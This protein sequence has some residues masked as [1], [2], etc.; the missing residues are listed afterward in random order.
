[1][2]VLLTGGTGYIGSHTAVALINAGLEV[3]IADDLSN[4]SAD[5]IDRIE[6]ICGKKPRFFNIDVRKAD[7]LFAVFDSC[8]IESTVHLAGFKAVGESVKVPLKYY[9]NNIDCALT[10]LE[11][12]LKYNVKNIV[13]SSSATVYGPENPIPYVEAMKTGPCSNPYGST[14]LMI[15]QII[16]DTVSANP[17]MSAVLL[18]YFNPVG[19]HQSGLMGELPA[20]IPNNLMPYITQVAAG[21]LERLNVFGNDYP[22]R[23]G[24]GVRDYIHVSDLAKG[25]VDAV[26]Y[27]AGHQGTEAINIGTGVGY[28]VL[29]LVKTFEREN[30]IPVPFVIAPRR[31]GDLAEFYADPSKAKSLLGWQAE[32]TLSDMC[33]DAWNWQKSCF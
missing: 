3:V 31:E 13:F 29:E 21:K 25:H 16:S 24:T 17:D 28:S 11:A 2:A 19:A 33:R 6:K 10:L 18:R 20:G 1:M 14:K 9:R 4:S 27:C 7:A 26:N 30:D 32:K 5:V 23:D 12:M 8:K 22:T 15:E